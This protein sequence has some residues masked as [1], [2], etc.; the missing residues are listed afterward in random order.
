MRE[1]PRWDRDSHKV[2]CTPVLQHETDLPE[3]DVQ[4]GSVSEVWHALDVENMLDL[5]PPFDDGV[6]RL[7]VHVQLWRRQSRTRQGHL[8]TSASLKQKS[9][10]W[11]FDDNFNT[12]M[13]QKLLLV[14]SSQWR[15]KAESGVE[16]QAGLHG[17]DIQ[18]I[19]VLSV[20]SLATDEE[21]L[22]NWVD[23]LLP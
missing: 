2:V 11:E 3:L 6:H 12:L 16:L 19:W 22:R 23:V 20:S 18:R 21:K 7:C 9:S 4:H 5:S 13:R 15:G 1:S 14:H 8:A 10:N 17:R